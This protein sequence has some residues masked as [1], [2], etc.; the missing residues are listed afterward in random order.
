VP[1]A[2]AFLRA[3]A[4]EGRIEGIQTIPQG[5]KPMDLSVLSGTA[6]GVPFQNNSIV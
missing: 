1:T 5:L 6:E 4:A 3:L 2:V